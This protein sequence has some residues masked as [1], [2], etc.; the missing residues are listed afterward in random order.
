[1][2]LSQRYRLLAPLALVGATAIAL[3]GCAEATPEREVVMAM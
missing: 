1:M 3:T 2:A